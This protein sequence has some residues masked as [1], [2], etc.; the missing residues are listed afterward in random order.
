VKARAAAKAKAKGAS[1]MIGLLCCPALAWIVL[2]A[3]TDGMNPAVRRVL[4]IL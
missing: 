3:L 4:R 1:F 2:P